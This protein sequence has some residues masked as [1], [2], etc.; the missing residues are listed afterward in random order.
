MGGI[1]ADLILTN[2]RVY[3]LD[4]A[5]PWAQAVACRDGRI[6][7]V[8]SNDEIAALSGDVRRAEVI[9]VSGR[10]VLPGFTDAHVHFA[11]YARRRQEVAL[12]GIDE[13]D[14]VLQR[15]RRG[16][17]R[18]PPGGWVEGWGWDESAWDAPPHRSVLDAVAPD[19]PVVLKRVD[20]HTWWVNSA[21]L[22]QAGI[23][24]TTPQPAVG[25]IER[26]ADG[27]PNGLLREWGAIEYIEACLPEPD[28][29]TLDAWLLDAITEAH[30][31]G[32]TGIHD[33]RVKRDG[34]ASLRAFQRLHDRGRLDLR[35]HCNV[36]AGHL[37]LVN[38]LGLCSGFG[39][40]RLW[41]GHMKT[42][43][44]GSM[45]STTAWMLEPYTNRPGDCGLVVTPM[46]E[47]EQMIR[48][49]AATGWRIAVHAIG[50]RAVREVLDAFARAGVG[51][52]QPARD[53]GVRHRIEHVQL[54]HPDDISRL[55]RGG[56]V[57]SMQPAHLTMD[58]HVADQVWGSRAR[59]AYA[60]RSLL[61][62]GTTLAF[63]SDAPVASFDP[64]VGIAAAVN[65]Q[66]PAGE[67]AGGWYPEER[68]SV[69]EAVRGY[70]LGPATVAG[71]QRLCGSL[72]PGK[73]ADMVVLTADLF[74]VEPAALAETSAYL[75]VFDGRVVYRHE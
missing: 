40:D 7:A 61:Q 20:M 63:G 10:L 31:L 36:A 38:E 9:D 11:A 41:L 28:D 66:D 42:F 22:R 69:A 62:H 5:Q 47:I 12:D 16:V 18:T 51:D 57:A 73:A 23:T 55:N 8:G 58:R 13:L 30:S 48:Q 2:G 75:T 1:C 29:A 52:A 56:I 21:A 19:T 49:C 35:V 64:L 50:D 53:G 54:I 44:D 6:L 37:P 4:T 14:T 32:I 45:G 59:H 3:T 74:S 15:V 67:P 72:T 65:R 27:K 60:F 25:R 71:K 26:D 46:D 33:Q 43:A 24:R 17:E 70:T 39:D 34:R 68:I